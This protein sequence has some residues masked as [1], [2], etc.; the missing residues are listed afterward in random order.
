MASSKPSPRQRGQRAREQLPCY[1]EGFVE[2]RAQG[3]KTNRRF[4]TCLCG[5]TLFFYNN[6]KDST[7]VEKLE[8]SGF[9]SLTDDSSRDKNL[10]A[11]RLSLRMR[12]GEI[13]LTV[14]SLEARE[15]WKGFI[16]SVVKLSV[17]SSLILLPGQLHMLHEVVEKETARRQVKPLS[18]SL[19][20]D[21]LGDMPACFLQVS[22][23]EA[24]VLLERHPSCGSLL[25][26]PR[27]SGTS[28]AATTRQEL[29]GSAVIKHYRVTKREQGGFLIDVENPIQCATLH[30]VVGTL[31]QKTAGTLRPFVPEEAYEE[32]ISDCPF[33]TVPWARTPSPDPESDSDESLYL[34][35]PKGFSDIGETTEKNNVLSRAPQPP[36]KPVRNPQ[37]GPQSALSKSPP[38]SASSSTCP[39]AAG[40][41]ALKPPLPRA[42]S[43]A[44]TKTENIL[45][46]RHSLVSA[47]PLPQMI[48]E[49][50]RLKLEKRRLH[51]D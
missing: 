15:L 50:L 20:I 38:P 33:F 5:D 21:V 19:Y 47:D 24:E 16:H 23:T 6:S 3:D 31:I 2:K 42:S 46:P 10:E 7:Y 36:P 22:R 28:F 17:P 37:L 32:S 8:L 9:V 41:Q 1:Y 39:P 30:D 35:D 40:R 49:E 25:L 11:G 29:D 51:Q 44:D 48:T 34:N 43:A 14:P 18:P 27:R 12:D 45:R 13:K 4:W 26:R